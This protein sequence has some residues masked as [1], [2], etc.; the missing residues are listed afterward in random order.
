MSS[1]SLRMVTATSPR[2]ATALCTLRHSCTG[3]TA[4]QASLRSPISV[5]TRASRSSGRKSIF[6]A[7]LAPFTRTASSESFPNCALNMDNACKTTTGSRCPSTGLDI[8]QVSRKRPLRRDTA[9]SSSFMVNCNAGSCRSI[10]LTRRSRI[11]PRSL[12]VD[13]T[14]ETGTQSEGNWK[15]C[16]CSSFS[17][18]LS[19]FTPTSSEAIEAF[20][21]STHST[22]TMTS[23]VAPSSTRLSSRVLAATSSACVARICS[24]RMA[25]NLPWDSF[26]HVSYLRFILP[27]T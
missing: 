15:R 25:P 2:T 11:C 22:P 24:S 23:F 20:T 12:N 4:V 21:C 13:S 5:A 7:S 14:L 19:S 6:R 18:V 3:K 1:R 8:L 9:S 26:C 17:P 27:C 10:A 16:A